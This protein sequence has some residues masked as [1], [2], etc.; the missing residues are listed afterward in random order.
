[1]KILLAAFAFIVAALLLA[2]SGLCAHSIFSIVDF[3]EISLS[4]DAEL[5]AGLAVM[6]VSG[7]IGLL[8]AVAGIVVLMAKPRKN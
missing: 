4:D 2:Y 5:Q 6:G 1:M 8:F 3:S 7:L